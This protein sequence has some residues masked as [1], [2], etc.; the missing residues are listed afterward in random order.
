MG[1]TA[2]AHAPLPVGPGA[3]GALGVFLAVVEK[4]SFT[5]AAAALGVSTSQVSRRLRALEDGLGVRLVERTTRQVRLTGAGQDYHA[6]VLPL[7]EGL[8]EAARDA[9]R[10]R[11]EPRGTLRIALP[12]TFGRHYLTGPIA[13]F[14]ERWPEVRVEARYSDRTVDLAAEGF[15][16]GIRGVAHLDD[17][18]GADGC[19]EEGHGRGDRR[20]GG[21]GAEL[22]G[23][24]TG[25]ADVLVLLEPGV[26]EVA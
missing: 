19:G 12:A 9:A 16:L 7:V 22:L 2:R 26:R 10:L 21:L 11:E 24:G 15:D 13:R 14:V 3:H 25:G 5:A 4:G 8:D 6:R 1:P 18:L 17:R 23:P 20:G